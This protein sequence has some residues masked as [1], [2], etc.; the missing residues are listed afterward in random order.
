MKKVSSLLVIVGLLVSAM[1]ATVQATF[2]LAEKTDKTCGECH[3]G[4]RHHGK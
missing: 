2:E 3:S 1:C 4:G